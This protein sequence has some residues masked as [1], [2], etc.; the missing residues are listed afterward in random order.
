M[1]YEAYVK[2]GGSLFC[3]T[4]LHPQF[5]YGAYCP[6]FKSWWNILTQYRDKWT[7]FILRLRWIVFI[8]CQVLFCTDFSYLLY[9]PIWV[10]HVKH[11]LWPL[12]FFFSFSHHLSMVGLRPSSLLSTGCVVPLRG[13]WAIFCH[14]DSRRVGRV[15][16]AKEKLVKYSAVANNW[17]RVT[18]GTDSEIYSFS[19]WAIMT[20][21]CQL[22]ILDRV[23][24]WFS[25]W[26]MQLNL[27]KF[28][29]NGYCI[30]EVQENRQALTWR[31][32]NDTDPL[33]VLRAKLNWWKDKYL[34]G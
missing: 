13:D 10:I 2:K 12:S 1:H 9:N 23:E 24:V 27:E 30:Q 17:T 6:A 14:A 3:I 19:H 31:W 16:S 33:F 22:M 29:T 21:H 4:L 34:T 20:G 7:M 28:L 15:W 5:C 26:F 18:R 25:S 8:C 32:S 11:T